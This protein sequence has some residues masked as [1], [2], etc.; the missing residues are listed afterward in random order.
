LALGTNFQELAS[1]LNCIA[2]QNSKM[3]VGATPVRYISFTEPPRVAHNRHSVGSA[4][5]RGTSAS[6]LA[7]A[8]IEERQ[9]GILASVSKVFQCALPRHYL[10]IPQ[11][12]P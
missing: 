2:L 5:R 1:H 6:M 7:F 3:T 8:V 11:H 9:A 4:V 12:P 10:V